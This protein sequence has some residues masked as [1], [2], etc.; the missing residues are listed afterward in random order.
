MVFGRK[1]KQPIK[2]ALFFLSVFFMTGFY[3]LLSYIYE[4]FFIVRAHRNI[5]MVFVPIFF[6]LIA[7]PS[8]FISVYFSE[9]YNFPVFILVIICLFDEWFHIHPL[10]V[11]LMFVSFISG[12]VILISLKKI[13]KFR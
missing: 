4:L 8:L 6:F 13:I 11:I 12:Y 2:V 7:S 3:T 10:R 1:Y 5:G 9:K